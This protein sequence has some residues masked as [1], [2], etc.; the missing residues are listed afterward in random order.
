[1]LSVNIS[2][3]HFHLKEVQLLNFYMRRLRLLL[4]RVSE[5]NCFVCKRDANT[6]FVK[7][8]N[9]EQPNYTAINA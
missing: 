8:C 4:H 9:N 7:Y 1:M 6:A 2:S 5:N 3:F